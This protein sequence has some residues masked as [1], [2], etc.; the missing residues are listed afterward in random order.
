MISE[1]IAM[2]NNSGFQESMQESKEELFSP[3][4]PIQRSVSPSDTSSTTDEINHSSG[5]PSAFLQDTQLDKSA[6]SDD[7][8]SMQLLCIVCQCRSLFAEC[9]F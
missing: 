3:L 9:M 1:L 6:G 4:S 5:T 7:L 8:Q 2:P